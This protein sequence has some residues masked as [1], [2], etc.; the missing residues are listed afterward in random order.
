MK[1]SS[2]ENLK[3][4]DAGTGIF[5]PMQPLEYNEYTVKIL[6]VYAYSIVLYL[7][8]PYIPLLLSRDMNFRFLSAAVF[9]GIIKQILQKLHHLHF[10]SQHYEQIAM[11]YYRTVF[12]YSCIKVCHS[13][14]DHSIAI[15]SLQNPVGDTCPGIS[16]KIMGSN[17]HIIL[18][19]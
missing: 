1:K 9:N 14:S 15:C 2:K 13:R 8:Y 4:S 12:T 5:I 17:I 19:K 18:T 11:S 3:V 16:K 7:K 10:I 6:G